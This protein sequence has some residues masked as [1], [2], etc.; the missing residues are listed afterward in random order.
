[1]PFEKEEEKA[2]KI[3]QFFGL[4]SENFGEFKFVN[5]KSVSKSTKMS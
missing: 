2:E 1:M 5:L 3:G 4:F